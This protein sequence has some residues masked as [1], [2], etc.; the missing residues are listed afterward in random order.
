MWHFLKFW[1]GIKDDEK[2]IIISE[3]Q[4]FHPLAHININV[5]VQICANRLTCGHM[6]N[7]LQTKLR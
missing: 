3:K 6:D 2:S 4:K 5:T 7:E 1:H